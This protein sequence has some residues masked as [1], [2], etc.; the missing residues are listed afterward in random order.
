MKASGARKLLVFLFTL[1]ITGMFVSFGL[2]VPKE[3]AQANDL[4]NNITIELYMQNGESLGAAYISLPI[5]V[6]TNPPLLWSIFV[7]VNQNGS[8]EHRERAVDQVS[9]PAES[10]THLSFP[11]LFQGHRELEKL[12]DLPS[13]EMF[14]VRI[15]REPPQKMPGNTLVEEGMA[16]LDTW[17]IGEILDPDPDRV[18]GI[19]ITTFFSASVGIPFALAQQ[20]PGGQQQINEMNRGV[21]DLGAR[22]GKQ[23]ECVPLSFANSLLWLAQTHNFGNKMP[24]STDNLVD[25]L[26]SDMKW[27]Q[28]GVKNEDIM[29]GKEAFTARHKLPLVNKKIENEVD[30]GRS[31]LWDK[32]VAELDRGED[33]ELIIDFKP[34]PN[35]SS[36]GGHA[37]TVVGANNLNRRQNILVHDPA[38]PPNREEVYTV[39]RNGQIVGYAKKAYVNFIVSE[40]FTTSTQQ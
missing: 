13:G 25:E 5:L 33:V 16:T 39:D 15:I 18:G 22:R 10:G 35:S 2:L 21:P 17:D 7:D 20:G 19:P 28:G 31:T 23:N 1:G 38:T 9:A 12:L 24:T 3:W 4:G 8:F 14:A 40:S 27:T 6:D 37:V 36:T 34:S 29:T 32:I 26:A 11:L 30:N